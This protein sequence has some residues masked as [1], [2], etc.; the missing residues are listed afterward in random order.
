MNKELELICEN[1]KKDQTGYNGV[2]IIGPTNLVMMSQAKEISH[3]FSS[4]YKLI[5]LTLNTCSLMDMY[6]AIEN[7]DTLIITG[8]EYVD[9]KILDEIYGL[10]CCFYPGVL[11]KVNECYP[12]G[13]PRYIRKHPNFKCIILLYSEETYKLTK[14]IRNL[15]YVLLMKNH[16]PVIFMSNNQL[17][18]ITK[19]E[20]EENMEYRIVL[21]KG[22]ASSLPEVEKVYNN[23]KEG[24]TIVVFANGDKIRVTREKDDKDDLEKAIAIAMVKYAYGLDK[25]LDAC[26][27]V[28]DSTK[29]EKLKKVTKKTKDNKKIKLEIKEKMLYLN[30]HALSNE[31]KEDK[32]E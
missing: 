7:G 21:G 17:K 14:P 29:K 9:N 2:I 10:L 25:Y 19:P 3:K 27:R 22:R 8:M 32:S 30:K 1:M 26:D 23:K 20:E 18:T 5:R 11:W 24:T 13:K 31:E 6:D 4:D 12:N 16:F 15:D 28:V